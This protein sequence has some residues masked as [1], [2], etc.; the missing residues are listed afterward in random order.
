MWITHRNAGRLARDHA[1]VGAHAHLL[2][3]ATLLDLEDPKIEIGRLREPLIIPNKDEREGYVPN[4]LYSC[5]A[6]IH[7]EE[8][9]IPYG[10]SDYASTF[11]TV[12]LKDLLQKVK[13]G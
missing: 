5:G 11:A 12:H 7:N 8:L 6:L 4:V 3:G 9:L 2:P 13:E 1:R 10:L